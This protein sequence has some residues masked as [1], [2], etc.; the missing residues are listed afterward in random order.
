[1]VTRRSSLFSSILK[2]AF[3]VLESSRWIFF[4][5]ACCGKLLQLNLFQICR[6]LTSKISTLG[7]SYTNTELRP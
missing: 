6:Y 7:F 5:V 1:M 4:N 2:R 3:L